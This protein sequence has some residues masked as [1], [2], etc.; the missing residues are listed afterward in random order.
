MA[1]ET[2]LSKKEKARFRDEAYKWNIQKCS[3]VTRRGMEYSQTEQKA[4]GIFNID[5]QID[6]NIFFFFFNFQW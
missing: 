4:E 2:G 1:S 5:Y 3:G 6:K